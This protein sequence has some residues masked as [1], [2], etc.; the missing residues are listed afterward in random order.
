MAEGT[1]K[2]SY[3]AASI[4]LLC[5]SHSSILFG[6]SVKGQNASLSLLTI[7]VYPGVTQPNSIIK[8]LPRRVVPCSSE[9][10]RPL[11]HIVSAWLAKHL[12]DNAAWLHSGLETGIV[13]TCADMSNPTSNP[14][15][16]D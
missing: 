14:V 4:A 11:E 7:S 15:L 6:N 12:E 13:A 10:G 9:E 8:E 1:A 5:W 16:W 3:F 2:R